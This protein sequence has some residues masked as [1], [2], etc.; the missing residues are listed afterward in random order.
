M[1]GEEERELHVRHVLILPGV[2]PGVF[3]NGGSTNGWH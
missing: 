1:L 2:A 3:D